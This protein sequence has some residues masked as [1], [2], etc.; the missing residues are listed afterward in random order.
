MY[1]ITEESIEK[2]K[3]LQNYKKNTGKYISVSVI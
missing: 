1:P 2:R 3:I